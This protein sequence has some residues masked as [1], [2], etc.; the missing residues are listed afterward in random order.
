MKKEKLNI[1][2]NLL[3]K[4]A[5]TACIGLLA[6]NSSFAQETKSKVPSNASDSFVTKTGRSM[7]IDLGATIDIDAKG[8]PTQESQKILYDEMDYQGA[9]SAY[10]Q[11]LPQVSYMGSLNM[12]RYYGATGNTDSLVLHNDP[13][14]DGQLT[15]NRVVT[16]LFN[17]ANI[18]ETGPMVYEA[19]AGPI[20]G[21]IM[22]SQMRW[23]TD[24]ANF[25][26]SG[27]PR[28]EVS[29]FN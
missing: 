9:V 10:L 1:H 19:P 25:S 14:T 3:S 17:F 22:D 4:L 12:N 6:T 8:Y 15:P 23:Y 16:Y 21:I 2:T 24:W 28:S 18:S 11:S 13:A 5:I 27:E 29:D 7:K 20:A 26:L